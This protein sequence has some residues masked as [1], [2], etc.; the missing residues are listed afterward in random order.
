MRRNKLSNRNLAR[1][2]SDPK[3]Y[4]YCL[5]GYCLQSSWCAEVLLVVLV[6]WS[7]S[8]GFK[9]VLGESAVALVVSV[10]LGVDPVARVLL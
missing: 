5:C 1:L 2:I 4:M 9:V 7:G 10:G 3:G 6:D 8:G